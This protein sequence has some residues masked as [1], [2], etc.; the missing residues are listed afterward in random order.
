MT[1]RFERYHVRAKETPPKFKIPTEFIVRRFNNCTNI[2]ECAQS[3]VFGVHV[4]GADGK[5]LEP[6][7]DLCRGCFRCVLEC[8]DL[9]VSVESNPVFQRMGNSYFTA[10]RIRTIYFESQSGKVPVSGTGY[11]GPFAGKG[12]DDIW[13][14][15][16]EI[17][18]PTRDGIHG[19]EYISTSVDLGKKPAR[20]Q[21]DAK[22]N[23][24]TKELNL[25]EIPIP[26]IF[27]APIKTRY[28]IP[29]SVAIAKAAAELETFA[30]IP[31]YDCQDEILPYISSIIPVLE[32]SEIDAAESLIGQVKILELNL[33]ENKNEEG[34]YLSRL[35]EINP[36]AL[37]S[38]KIDYNEK[39]PEKAYEFAKSGVDIIHFQMNDEMIEQDPERVT[40]AIRRT[41]GYLVE[42]KI[43]DEV[44][45]IT[46]GGIAEA[47]H[48][49]KS[50]ILG[51]DAVGIGLAYQIAL[52][53]K[54]CYQDQHFE[55]CPLQ[56]QDLDIDWASQRII[57]LIGA[58]RDQLL[59]VLG[60]MGLREVRRQRGEL[61]RMM[62]YKD[63]ESR[64][65]GG[66][67]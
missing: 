40:N 18:R 32:P 52:G 14:D 55:D 20:L 50:I 34:D 28:E 63:L 43:R 33:T 45:I 58:W 51:A 56:I 3:C 27:D 13:F 19:R 42:K 54:V 16:S 11:G 21:F 37:I 9:A 2:Q 59:E 44:T 38:V 25:V 1:T 65:F 48:I 10:D 57:N 6:R 8:P 64:I 66:K 35:K 31:F 4:V 41:H 61:G 30:L 17:V 39:S 5:V 26:M 7:D 23:L 15:F 36:T 12:F 22:G 46:S 49:P 24:M 29:L 47:A 62:S 60:G 67:E 53:C